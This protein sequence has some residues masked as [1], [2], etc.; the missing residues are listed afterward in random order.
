MRSASGKCEP[1]DSSTRPA[2]PEAHRCVTA[3]SNSNAD[4]TV[5]GGC[6]RSPGFGIKARGI[7]D[8]NSTSALGSDRATVRSTTLPALRHCHGMPTFSGPRLTAS[9][10]TRCCARP[11]KGSVYLFAKR[12]LNEDRQ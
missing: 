1:V 4:A 10:V 5:P 9:A 3:K 12:S 2:W 6:K 7:V 8:R 11:R